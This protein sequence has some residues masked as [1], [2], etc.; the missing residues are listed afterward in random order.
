M[1]SAV[2]GVAAEG[3]V[4]DALHVDSYLGDGKGAEAEPAR[5]ERFDDKGRTSVKR[6]K[7]HE[8]LGPNRQPISPW[9]PAR[10]HRLAC[11][12]P[13]VVRRIEPGPPRTSLSVCASHWRSSREWPRSDPRGAR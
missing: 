4:E 12:C 8:S 1:Q 5:C 3:D 6:G 2:N 9:G 7:R 10:N 11:S 13:A